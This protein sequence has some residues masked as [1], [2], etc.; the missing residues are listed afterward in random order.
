MEF[1]NLASG[2]RGN[3]SVISTNNVQLMIDDGLNLRTLSERA[4][5]ANIDLSKTNAILITHEHSDHVKGIAAFAKNTLFP[6][7]VTARAKSSSTQ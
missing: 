3:C 5:L 4:R 7:T 1:C 2:S 6:C